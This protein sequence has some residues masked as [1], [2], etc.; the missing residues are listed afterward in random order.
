MKSKS[1]IRSIRMRGAIPRLLHTSSWRG[2]KY[3]IRLYGVVL[4]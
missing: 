1:T 4:S 2:V 3:R